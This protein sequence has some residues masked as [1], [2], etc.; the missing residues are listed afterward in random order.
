[1]AKEDTT[2]RIVT[3]LLV[4]AASLAACGTPD[5]VASA[6]P[7]AGDA[8]GDLRRQPFKAVQCWQAMGDGGLDALAPG[9]DCS[10]AGSSCAPPEVCTFD[11]FAMEA[12]CV[13]V[14]DVAR[15]CQ[16]AWM[17]SQTGGPVRCVDCGD[18]WNCGS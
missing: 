1:M 2:M 4:A 15:C 17:R 18:G 7:D 14:D 16:I 11:A 8:G 6:S 13:A 10:A 3:A 12:Q 5:T 9:S